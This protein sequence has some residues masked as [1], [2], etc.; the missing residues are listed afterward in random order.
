VVRIHPSDIP[1]VF[2]DG[3]RLYTVNL[4]PGVAVYGEPLVVHDGVEYRPWDPRRSKLA[5]LLKKGVG[6]FPFSGRTDVLYLGAAQGTTVSHLSD[7]CAEGTIYAVEVSRRAFQKLFTLSGRRPNIMPILADAEAPEAYRRVVGPVDVLYQDIAQRDQVSIFRKNLEFLR[8]GGFGLLMIKARSADV[9]AEPR[10]VY[11]AARRQLAAAG[12][13]VL[14]VVELDP[15]ERDHAAAL[16][17][18]P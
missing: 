2:T 13:E 8:T 6:V 7:I 18:K 15:Y 1:R 3:D 16:V 5:A 14:E 9:T 10:D 17:E 4:D 12:L 11:A